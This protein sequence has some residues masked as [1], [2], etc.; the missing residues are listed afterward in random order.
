[1]ITVVMPVLPSRTGPGGL[2]ERALASVRAQTLP[3]TVLSVAVD[4]TGDGAAATRN[5]ALETVG[6]EL[7]AFLDDDDTLKPDHLKACARHMRLTGADVVYPGYDVLAGEDPV[8]CFGLPFDPVLL[9]RRN[10]I[11]VTA[12]C[13]A[14]AVKAVGGF[15]DHPDEHGKPCEDWGLWLALLDAG[16]TFSHLPA[17]TW[18][19]RVSGGTEGRGARHG[20]GAG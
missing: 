7:V 9:R 15:V 12:L 20:G 8:G 5:R 11:P 14:E 17:R 19:W 1:M 4:V 13:R 10:Y 6:T 16:A 18:V 3:A 2:Y